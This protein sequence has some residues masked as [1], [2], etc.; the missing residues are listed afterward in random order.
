MIANFYDTFDKNSDKGSNIPQEVLNVLSE[1]LPTTFMYYQDAN[2]KYRVGPKPEHLSDTMV[3]KVDIS[4]D[5]V[6]KY[7]KDIPRDKWAEYIYRMQLHVPVKNI[8]IGDKEK[9]IPIENTF[10]NPL[11]SSIEVQESY[12]IPESFPPAK[13][14]EFE[15]VEGDRVAINI[16]RKPHNSLE[17]ILFT[18]INFPALQIRFI[19]KN[20]CVDSKVTYTVTPTKADTVLDA[21]IS[22]HLFNGLYNGTVKINGKKLSGPI[23][24]TL[25]CDIEQLKSAENFWITAKKLEDKLGVTFI[26]TAE[27]PSEDV[28]FFAQ[29]EQCIL[30][31]KT[32]GWEHPFEHFHISKIDIKDGKIED[33]LE[34]E[35]VELVFLEG[36]I[37]ATLLGAKFE[38]YSQ[39][40]LS[41]MIITNVIWDNNEKNS[42]EFYVSDPVGG[43]WKLYRKFITKEQ[44]NMIDKK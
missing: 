23:I 22:I 20:N 32:I 25:S 19:L 12:I 33:I 7:L 29:L 13:L 35:G 44:R 21:L 39:T 34:K 31:D 27:F 8:K 41:N 36:P 3:F 10:G 38:L 16:E 17:E 2:G 11:N 42:G 18:N 14:F 43:K 30:E 24:G 28:K 40:K 4:E 5:F 1:E 6:N 15:T 9:Q 26:P 37:H